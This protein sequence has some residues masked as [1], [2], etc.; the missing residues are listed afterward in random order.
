MLHVRDSIVGNEKIRGI[1]GGEKR[2]LTLTTELGS[3]GG[4]RLWECIHF[5]VFKK[6]RGKLPQFFSRFSMIKLI[7]LPSLVETTRP[8][9]YFFISNDRITYM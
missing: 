2:R 3:L 7:Y 8:E 6:N 5:F 1:S 4:I 9:A